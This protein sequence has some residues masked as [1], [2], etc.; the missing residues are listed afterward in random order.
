[1]HSYTDNQIM[2]FPLNKGP[3]Y[4]KLGMDF[5]DIFH[6]LATLNT[7]YIESKNVMAIACPVTSNDVI[8]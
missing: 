2:I 3:V 5:V 8:I 7:K 4:S 1:M 6:L